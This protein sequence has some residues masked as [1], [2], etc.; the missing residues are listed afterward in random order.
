MIGPGERAADALRAATDR[1]AAVSATARI[2]AE[3]LMAHAAGV[4]RGALLL[5]LRD[6]TV[7][8]GFDALVA[9]RMAHEPVAY[10]VGHRDFWTVR[11][12]VGPGV[13]VPRADS[14]TLIEAAV[15]AF[16]AGGPARVLDLGCG[17]GTLLCAALDQWPCATGLGMERSAAAR[18]YAARNVGALGL[19]ARA[20]IVAGDWTVPG[21]RTRIDGT[22]DLIL[23]NPPYVAADAV[24]MRE[25]AAHEPHA[26][27]YAGAEGMDDYNAIIPAL[28]GLLADG[29]VAVVEL[30]AGQA[31]AV[32]AIAAAAGLSGTVRRDLGGIDRALVLRT[33]A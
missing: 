30:G 15:E 17:P 13:L 20:R 9:R 4:S 21:W 31:D 3:L 25:V 8:A 10:I 26:A 2:D 7:P 12:A 32:R 33:D 28:T 14:E 27:L 19:A 24:L 23:A 11:I 18:D 5:E 29:G 1:L 6:Q 22:F 16:G